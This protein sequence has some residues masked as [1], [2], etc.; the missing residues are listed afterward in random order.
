[1]PAV[2]W[3]FQFSVTT[4]FVLEVGEEY[5]KFY[6]NGAPVMI[7]PDPYGIATP[8]QEADL[9]DLKYKQINDV[10]YIVHPLY[11]WRKLSRSADTDW[12]L[13]EV[14][15]MQPPTLDENITNITIFP[16]A[17]SGAVNLVAS[18][19]LFQAGHVGSYWRIGHLRESAYIEKF[20]STDVTSQDLRIL[21][22]YAVRTYG[23]WDGE[24]Q[25]QRI[26][27]DWATSGA[28]YEVVRKWTS[29]S[30]RNIDA[31][32]TADVDALYRLVYTAYSAGSDNRVVLE[33]VEAVI[34][35]VVKITSVTNSTAAACQT[36][37]DFESTNG[38][39]RWQEA[40]FSDYRGHP[41]TVELHQ[42][43]LMLGGTLFQPQTVYGSVIG[44]FENHARGTN[45]DAAVVFTLGDV[46]ANAINWMVSQNSDLLIGTLAAEWKVS[47]S[48]AI[49]AF[50][51]TTIQANKQSTYGS[52]Y[53]AAEVVDGVILYVQRKGRKIRE[54]VYSYDTDKF[55]S[56]DLTL[57]A[58]HISEGGLLQVA[59]QTEPLPILWAVTGNG[60]L[61]AL[62]YAR[63]QQVVGWHRHP[64]DGL[65]ESVTTIFGE[66]NADD[67]VWIIVHRV[68]D[69]DDVR[70]VER[71]DPTYWT[72]KEDAYFVDAG[73]TWTGSAATVIPGLDH[74]EGRLVDALANGTVYQG[75]LVTAGAITLPVAATKVQAGLP[76]VSQIQ[77]M[78]I[79]SDGTLGV[80]AGK[81]RRIAEVVLR[82]RKTLGILWENEHKTYDVEVAGGGVNQDLAATPLQ[83]K[84]RKINSHNDLTYDSKLIVRQE[85]PLPFILQCLV[86]K[87]DVTG[88]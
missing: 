65:V 77:P 24:L 51:P 60:A 74:L 57:L 40:A 25:L 15:P 29:R 11:A 26:G 47:T 59:V 68:V 10:L 79:D 23:V 52:E 48:S 33:A 50:T 55:V 80:Y 56:A 18:D 16:S 9:R 27:L 21:G 39:T 32:G 54:L 64:T 7:G 30:D 17:L 13:E 72:A 82:V 81:V 62:T 14:V 20:L 19:P 73:I 44:D 86:C 31:E 46:Q 69:G 43:R 37:T 35:A 63:D 6:T 78:R 67:E 36:L 71:I 28:S 4:T 88:K 5:I 1:M 70:F 84:D 53:I 8:Y 22:A 61:I 42:Q 83:T 66:D 45:D 58:E 2:L 12:F 41:R 38:T 3:R 49:K 87:Y 75:L 34:Y 85:K 76:F